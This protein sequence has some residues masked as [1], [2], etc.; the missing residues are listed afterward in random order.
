MCNLCPSIDALSAH[1]HITANTWG[2]TR[3]LRPSQDGA[4]GGEEEIYQEAA[5]IDQQI[6]SQRKDRQLEG[7]V[8]ILFGFLEGV[9]DGQGNDEE[10]V[11]RHDED[12]VDAKAQ[13][14]MDE[15]VETEVGEAHPEKA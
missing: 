10:P 11:G 3:S 6:G 2:Q 14:Q 13:Y 9:G 5:V 7:L 8:L 12:L 15:H 1:W 4:D